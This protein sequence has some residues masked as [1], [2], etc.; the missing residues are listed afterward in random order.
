[1]SY[2]EDNLLTHERVLLQ[3]HRHWITFLTWRGI[4]TLF[5][6]PWLDR[7][8]SEFAVTDR[9]VMIKVGIFARRTVDLNLSKVESVDVEQGFFARMLG[10][11][12]L[13]VVGTGGTREAFSHIADPFEFRRVVQQ[14]SS[15]LQGHARPTALAAPV[16]DHAARLAK[17]KG[18]LDQGLITPE[19]YDAQRS[20]ILNDL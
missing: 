6:G 7:K 9:R 11:G 19:E 13:V 14:A 16:D 20:R 15:D 4:L 17:A 12:T 5:I 1:M 3:T 2:V 18:L 10:Y 8:C